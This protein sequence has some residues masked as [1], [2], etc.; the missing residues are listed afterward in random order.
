M[1]RIDKVWLKNPEKVIV[2][3]FGPPTVP[4]CMVG[5]RKMIGKERW[6]SVG[7]LGIRSI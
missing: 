2:T 7:E 1:S 3:G 4:F 6:L 5:T